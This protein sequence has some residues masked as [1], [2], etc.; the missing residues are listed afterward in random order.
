M[1]SPTKSGLANLLTGHQVR[2]I[3]DEDLG[4]QIL[5]DGSKD[6]SLS[7]AEGPVE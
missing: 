5:Y 1:V 3:A 4:L 2:Q 6:A 7:E